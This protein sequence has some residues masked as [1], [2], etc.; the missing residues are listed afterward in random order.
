MLKEV[1]VEGEKEQ[2]LGKGDTTYFEGGKRH[3]VTNILDTPAIGL[4][5]FVPGWSFDFWLKRKRL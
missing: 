3:I 1:L 2:V 5:I 4:D